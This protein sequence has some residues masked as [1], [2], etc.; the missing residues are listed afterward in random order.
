MF[1]LQG[2]NWIWIIL[3]FFLLFGSDGLGFNFDIGSMFGCGNNT[4]L[5]VA[6]AAMFLLYQG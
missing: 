5:I 6:L 3:A 1:G 4:M 2:N